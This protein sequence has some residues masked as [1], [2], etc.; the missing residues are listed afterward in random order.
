[1]LEWLKKLFGIV[2]KQPVILLNTK[3]EEQ[4]KDAPLPLASEQVVH[5][6]VIVGHTK[7]AQG[8]ELVDGTKRM[9]EYAYNSEIAKKIEVNALKFPRIKVTTFF[10]DGVGISGAYNAARKAGCDCVIE[11]HFN[12]FNKQVKGTETL[13]TPDKGDIEFANIVHRNMCT[14]FQRVGASRGVRVIGRSV[15]GAPN[16]YAFP[17]GVNCLVEPFFGDSEGNIGISKSEDYA[18]VLLESVQLWARQ[19]DLVPGKF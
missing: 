14:L 19:L 13:C 8:A 6:G 5:L 3:V 12:A 1:M 2:E 7:D 16:V 15:R 18:V 4:I 17:E 10:R 9:T 11:L